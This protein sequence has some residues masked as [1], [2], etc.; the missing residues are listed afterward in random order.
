M[1]KSWRSHLNNEDRKDKIVEWSSNY[2]TSVYEFV[3]EIEKKYRDKKV[4]FNFRD[5]QK[6]VT[7]S[8]ASKV[9]ENS[10]KIIPDAQDF[11]KELDDIL[12]NRVND[13][14]NNLRNQ[15]NIP[16]WDPNDDSRRPDRPRP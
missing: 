6:A 8:L 7:G 16:R 12:K 5:L 4:G 14:E 9:D 10:T 13:R 1:K 15:Y 3:Q 11:K 2:W